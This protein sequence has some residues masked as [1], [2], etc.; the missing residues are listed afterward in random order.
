MTRCQ[1][2]FFD[3]ASKTASARIYQHADGYPDGDHGI[4]ERL[5]KLSV[6]LAAGSG[7]YGP[8]L[9]DPEWAA[10][11][12]I[13]QFREKMSGNIYVTQSVHCDIDYLYRVECGEKSW[14]VKV[15]N[16]RGSA[17]TKPSVAV[18]TPGKAVAV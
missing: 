10:A 14:K 13:S 7:I 3:E 8:R 6:V 1:I 2:E 17:R 5:R 15:I 16:R 4:L 11:E 18:L 9:N 12:F